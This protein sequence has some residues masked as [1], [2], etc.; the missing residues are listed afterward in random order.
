MKDEVEAYF[1]AAQAMLDLP[2]SPA[3]REEALTAFRVL[4]AQARLVT[5]FDVGVETE[6]AP[7]FTP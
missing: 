7:R 1:E 4:M 6:P 5:E 3:H 2:I